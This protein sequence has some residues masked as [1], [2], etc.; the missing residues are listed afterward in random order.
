MN[1]RDLLLK[2]LK[3][4]KDKGLKTADVLKYFIEDTIEKFNELHRWEERDFLEYEKLLENLKKLNKKKVKGKEKVETIEEDKEKVKTTEKGK[5]LENIVNFIIEKT[6]FFEV[7]ENIKTGTNE[8]DQI[9]RLSDRGKQALKTLDLDREL[10]QINEDVFLGECKNY[11]K[12]LGVTYVG[13]FYGLLKSCDCSF[14][15]IFTVEGLTGK[16]NSW[17]DS[18]G[19]TRVVRLIEKYELK[20]ENFYIIEFNIKDFERIKE[21]VSFFDIIKEK[22]LALQIGTNYNHLLEQYK[23]ND[24]SR[25]L[26]K[27]R[28]LKR[29]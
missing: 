26:E 12:P 8:I 10:L 29:S 21:G 24:K 27:F 2:E 28:D 9:I 18:Y 15:V 6:Y 20:N 19:L 13:K 17:G 25:V 1:E 4:I 23:R 22:K 14:G 7:Y 16:E 3:V 5:A 11:S